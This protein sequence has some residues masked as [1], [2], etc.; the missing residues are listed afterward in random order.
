MPGAVIVLD[1]VG[2]LAQLYAVAD[3]VFIGGSL[4][5]AGG[6]NMLEPALR[7][8]PVLFGPHTENFRDAAA[9]LTGSGGGIRVVDAG[10]LARELAR[11]LDDEALRHR[12]GAAAAEAVA[13]RRGAVK[14][15]MELVER[16]LKSAEVA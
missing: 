15:T 10:A 14:E 3:V 6:H 11:L 16:F 4:V 13:S 5:A 2:E 12:L 7:A 8:K 1:T 9:L